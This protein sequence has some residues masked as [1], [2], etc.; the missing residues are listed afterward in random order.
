MQDLI[1][2][3]AT[4]LHFTPGDSMDLAS[5]AEHA[6]AHP[7]EL[8]A[9]S[10]EA[11]RSYETTYTA[12]R[13][14]EMLLE[15]YE[16]AIGNYEAKREGLPIEDLNPTW[17]FESQPGHSYRVSGYRPNLSSSETAPVNQDQ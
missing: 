14:Y 9:M 15:T 16:R 6:W 8:E 3:G 4:G 2:D 13:N 11:R 10:N 5:K 12:A 17:R 7:E 1:T